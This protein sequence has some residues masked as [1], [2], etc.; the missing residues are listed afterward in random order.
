MLDGGKR[1]TMVVL[2]KK[3]VRFLPIDVL[4]Y[5][6]PMRCKFSYTFHAFRRA[7]SA[8]RFLIVDILTDGKIWR[9][10]YNSK[11]HKQRRN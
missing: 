9:E 2:R 5:D 1:L 7:T 11:L 4:I 6:L 3:T 10:I 8:F